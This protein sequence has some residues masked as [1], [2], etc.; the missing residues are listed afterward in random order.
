MRY[1]TSLVESLIYEYVARQVCVDADGNPWLGCSPVLEVIDE[2]N[3]VYQCTLEKLSDGI[4]RY[5]WYRVYKLVVEGSI[6]PSTDLIIVKARLRTTN[7][8][9][10]TVLEVEFDEPQTLEANKTY[11][12]AIGSNI[13]IE[14]D[15]EPFKIVKHLEMI[16][17]YLTE[18]QKREL[19][20]EMRELIE[21]ALSYLVGFVTKVSM[22]RMEVTQNVPSQSVKILKYVFT[23]SIKVVSAGITQQ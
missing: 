18:E 20:E 16:A 22:P 2:N 8:L 15:V 13:G 4:D 3:N 6:T 11:K 1:V 14:R 10:T 19:Y 23:Q 7:V 9:T 17:P 5:S 21:E 12:I